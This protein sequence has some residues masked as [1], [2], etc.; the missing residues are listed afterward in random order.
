[1]PR[2]RREGNATGGLRAQCKG[3]MARGMTA[4]GGV[5]GQGAA[6][7]LTLRRGDRRDRRWILALARTTFAELGDYREIITRWLDAS[8]VV[9]VVAMRGEIRVGFALIAPHRPIALLRP[10]VAELVGI[11]V[12]ARARAAGV[13]RCLLERAE[14]VARTWGAREVRL[15]TAITNDGARRFFA[16]AGY[17]QLDSE[18]SYYPRGQEAVEMGRVLS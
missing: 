13:G 16:R 3:D 12:Q 14:L 2:Q 9:S 18:P 15:H 4:D 10:R 7:C 5:T 8:G 17:R 11:A 1:M 6:L